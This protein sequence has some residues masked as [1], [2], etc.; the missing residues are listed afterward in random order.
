MRD[1][2]EQTRAARL[3]GLF[4]VGLGAALAIPDMCGAMESTDGIATKQRYVDWFDQNA[5]PRYGGFMLG[6]DCYMLRCSM[7]HRGTTQ[8]PRGNFSRF[9]FTEPGGI[10]THNN[11][12]NDA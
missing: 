11:I 1:Y 2:L 5:A 10:T 4:L 7:L 8:H 9:L 3:A 12:L 6:E